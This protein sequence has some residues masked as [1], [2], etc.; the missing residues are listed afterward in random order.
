MRKCDE[1]AN[2]V[3]AQPLRFNI[4]PSFTCKDPSSYQDSQFT[5]SSQES[6]EL[7]RSKTDQL[8]LSHKQEGLGI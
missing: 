1:G 4:P 3:L 6:S 7:D 5:V 2:S 8:F